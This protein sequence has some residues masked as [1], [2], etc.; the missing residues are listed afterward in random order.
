MKVTKFTQL[1]FIGEVWEPRLLWYKNFICYNTTMR[2]T[3]RPAIKKGGYT[4]LPVYSSGDIVFTKVDDD[5]ANLDVHFWS[6]TKGGYVRA[7]SNNVHRYLHRMILGAGNDEQVDHKNGDK[8]DNRRSNLRTVTN[9]QNQMSRHVTV[10]KSG[11]KGVYPIGSSYQ[12]KIKFNG[13]SISLGTYKTKETAARA[14]NNA[15]NAL[16]GEYALTNEVDN[17]TA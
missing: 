16:F 13:K 1:N 2:R 14:Y 11:F 4:L 15:A 12:A 9:Q 10:A 6:L 3:N 8:L 7:N 5:C 17:E